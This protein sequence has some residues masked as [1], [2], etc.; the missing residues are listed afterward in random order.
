MSQMTDSHRLFLQAFMSRG[1]LDAKE[2]K[3]LFRTSC[4]KFKTFI[5]DNEEE[6][7][8]QL[9]EFVITINNNIKPFHMEI[10]KGVSEEDGSNYYGLVNISESSITLL[11]SDFTT[12]ELDLFKK[13]VESI[14][15]SDT[16][17]V[18]ST[19]AINLVETLDKKMTR[20]DAQELLKKLESNKWIKVMNGQ[21][22]LATRAILE[23]E[24]YIFD[25]F[26]AIATRCNM[27]K[28]LCLK[29][30]SCDSCPVR[31]HF[32][33]ASKFF[34]RQEVPKCP[35]SDCKSPWPRALPRKD[36]DQPIS[37]QTDA[38]SGGTSTQTRKRKAKS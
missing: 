6:R 11:A 20:N 3:S 22:S 15:D 14:V 1:I 36:T 19:D 8:H 35:A 2:V 12:N 4:E 5:A 9:T 24:Q 23:L 27:C 25:M 28:K 16:G 21:V 10:K 7:R 32:H 34:S 18:G 30:Q 29:G 31:L 26:P 33:C 37:S 38:S 17:S 13:L